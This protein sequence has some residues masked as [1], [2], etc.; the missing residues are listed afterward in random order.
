MIL[1]FPLN[2]YNRYGRY[3]KLYNSAIHMKE[4]GQKWP[5]SFI[6]EVAGISNT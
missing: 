4:Q 1:P 5:C 2:L 6:P 3:K